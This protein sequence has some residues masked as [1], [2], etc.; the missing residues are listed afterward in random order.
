MDSQ[1]IIRTNNLELEF[2]ELRNDLFGSEEISHI[3]WH[4]LIDLKITDPILAIRWR[5]FAMYN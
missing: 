5:D 1:L 4:K 2:L 3:Q